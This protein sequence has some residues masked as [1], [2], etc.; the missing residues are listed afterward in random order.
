MKVPVYL[1]S[2]L[3]LLAIVEVSPHEEQTLQGQRFINLVEYGPLRSI[4]QRPDRT[5][6]VTFNAS[7]VTFKRVNLHNGFASTFALEVQ[8]REHV[9]VWPRRVWPRQRKKHYKMTKAQRKDRQQ[10]YAKNPQD[11][12]PELRRDRKFQD[13]VHKAP[14]P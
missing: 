10:H 2:T 6:A 4:P 11:T 7:Y 8:K 1:E 12:P 13:I 5:H 14:R 9:S 3:E